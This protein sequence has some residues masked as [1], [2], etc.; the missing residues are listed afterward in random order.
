[1]AKRRQS[2]DKRIVISGV[3]VALSVI[4]LYLGCAIEVLDLT[5]S[6]IASLFV[7]IAVIEMGGAYPW[8]IYAVTA[9]LSIM[10]LPNKFAALIYTA[11]AGFYPILKAYIEKI[12]GI[13]CALI[14]LA[15]FNLCLV[16]M[17]WI[18]RLF[19]ITLETKYGLPLTALAL[20]FIFILY[21]FALTRL[22]SRYIFVWRRKF[23][24]DKLNL[25]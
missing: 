7:I 3:L 14:K 18:S 9:A 11:F 4:I 13:V 19:V 16:G 1:M 17:W 5:M 21:D 8:L 6:V 20:N 2:F 24:I 22:I 12:Q 10:L 25:K 23:K 15:L